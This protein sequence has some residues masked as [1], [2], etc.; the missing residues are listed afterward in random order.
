[1]RFVTYEDTNVQQAMLVANALTSIGSGN[2]FV[3]NNGNWVKKAENWTKYGIIASF[4]L[5]R[6]DGGR[7]VQSHVYRPEKAEEVMQN[8]IGSDKEEE[9]SGGL[10]GY[11]ILHMSDVGRENGGSPIGRAGGGVRA[12]A[13]AAS[14]AREQ[15]EGDAA[16][17]LL[18]GRGTGV[19]RQPRPGPDG[20]AAGVHP[21]A[22]GAG[23]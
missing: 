1:M 16:A 21:G 18:P 7:D 14:G 23:K 4:A 2:E 15:R 9:K 5:V 12:G 19:L 6:T 3:M 17:Q 13:A 22:R 8:Y 20:G 11:A 10:Y